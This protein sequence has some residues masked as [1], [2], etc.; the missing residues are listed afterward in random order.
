[1]FSLSLP[2]NIDARF[3]V[4]V[5]SYKYDLNVSISITDIF[6]F[7]SKNRQTLTAIET[8]LLGK[9]GQSAEMQKFINALLLSSLGFSIPSVQ[10]TPYSAVL[11]SEPTILPSII[12]TSEP[13]YWPTIVPSVF[14]SNIPTYVTGPSIVPS[15]FPSNIPTYV[16]TTGPS[17]VPSIFP[18]NIPTYVPI[19]VNNTQLSATPTSIECSPGNITLFIVAGILVGVVLSQIITLM[20]NFYIQMQKQK[21]RNEVKPVIE[22]FPLC[23]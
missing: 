11:T 17:I 3:T 6:N 2:K 4:S 20:R 5:L 15:V 8:Q 9:L 13:T 7:L 14:P 16:P 21:H 18:S 10:I 19:M 12:P 22:H 1:M 23:N